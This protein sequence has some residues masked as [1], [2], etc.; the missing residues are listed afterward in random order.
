MSNSNYLN[1]GYAARMQRLLRLAFSIAVIDG[2][3]IIAVQIINFLLSH[4]GPQL[5]S[6]NSNQAGPFNI[7]LS[8]LLI[9]LLSILNLAVIIFRV[10]GLTRGIKH[11][12]SRCYEYALRR[13]PAII[14]LYL[15]CSIVILAISIQLGHFFP[16]F[17]AKLFT[18]YSKALM[19]TI[20]SLIP[21]AILACTFVVDLQYNA[22]RSIS[23]VYHHVRYKMDVPVLATIGILY[24]LPM[25]LGILDL[26]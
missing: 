5:P 2:G 11:P 14:A 12:I 26:S 23:A 25:C 20:F 15:I 3:T 19:F 16:N 8:H 18:N 6:L 24:N 10:S 13:L 4:F 21:F 1:I 9:S 7:N 22:F 17:M